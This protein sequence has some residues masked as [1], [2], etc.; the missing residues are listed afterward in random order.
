MV[1]LIKYREQVITVT[2]NAWND[3]SVTRMSSQS[4]GMNKSLDELIESYLVI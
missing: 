4:L 1:C 3:K 2:I